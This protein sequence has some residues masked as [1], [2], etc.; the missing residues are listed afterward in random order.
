MWDFFEDLFDDRFD[1]RWRDF[2]EDFLLSGLIW[3]D[4]SAYSSKLLLKSFK[5]TVCV[6]ALTLKLM[7]LLLRFISWMEDSSIK[8]LVCTSLRSTDLYAGSSLLSLEI[9]ALS[10]NSISEYVIVA[11]NYSG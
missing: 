3:Q 4:L 9:G 7:L 2:L 10:N 1:C 6:F 11:Y 8:L 5:A